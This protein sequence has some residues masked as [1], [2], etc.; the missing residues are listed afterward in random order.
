ML[1]HVVRRTIL[2]AMIIGALSPARAIALTADEQDAQRRRTRAATLGECLAALENAHQIT[3]NLH[4][5]VRAGTRV[6]QQPEATDPVAALQTLL[7]GYDFFLQYGDAP[8]EPVGRLQRVWVFPRGA[9][10]RVRLVREQDLV[11]E[12]STRDVGAQLNDALTRSAE[13]AQGVAARALEDPDENVRQQ[14]LEAI[15]RET[16]PVPDHLLEGVFFGD[17]FDTVRAAA[18]DALVARAVADGL[19]VTPTVDRA[20]QDPSPL[21]RDRAAALRESL[22]A[23][24]PPVKSGGE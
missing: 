19:D 14:A 22:G 10:E 7:R 12:P 5:S 11:V 15:L 9:A 16:L 13:E 24:A 18:F 17:P 8:G 23:D 21:V 2:A 6:A 1:M 4:P 3:I 20:L